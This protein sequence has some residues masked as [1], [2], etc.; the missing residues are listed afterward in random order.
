MLIAFTLVIRDVKRA[1]TL[2]RHKYK[3]ALI[4]ILLKIEVSRIEANTELVASH[5]VYKV[6]YSVNAVN[7]AAEIF[8]AYCNVLILDIF[9][10]YLKL[11]DIL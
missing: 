11:L 3:S 7:N 4:L 9:S 6:E 1:Q 8:K 10:N 5:A 2:A